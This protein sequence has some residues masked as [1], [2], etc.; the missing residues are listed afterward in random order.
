MDMLEQ[1]LQKEANAIKKQ[2]LSII[3]KD[4]ESFEISGNVILEIDK[5]IKKVKEY[6]KDLKG[7]AYDT[8]KGICKKESDMLSP[9]ECR[10]SEMRTAM[11]KF[12]T[13]QRRLEQEEQ[14][15]LNREREEQERKE[16]E[17][18]EKRAEK[19]EEKGQDEKAESLRE[20]A[21]QV[22]VPVSIVK[23]EVEKTVK[24]DGGT[25]TTVDDIIITITDPLKLLGE[26]Q[27]G[28]L[29]ISIVEFKISKI[30]EVVKLNA[31]NNLEGANIQKISKPVFRG[32][33]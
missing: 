32:K 6:W 19:A 16:K 5:I 25:I 21:E 24:T 26:V 18:L 9:L 1:E 23:P 28:R 10:R 17:K 11:T 12:S 4:R 13:E 8:W 7:D 30:K 31:I 2:A 20:Q 3:V 27:R 29:P 33:K 14:Q 22:S 15:R